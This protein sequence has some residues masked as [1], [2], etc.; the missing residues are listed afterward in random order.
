MRKFEYIPSKAL[1]EESHIFANQNAL[2][3]HSPVTQEIQPEPFCRPETQFPLDN[4]VV[5]RRVCACE[6]GI[7]F[8][9]ANFVIKVIDLSSIYWLDHGNRDNGSVENVRDLPASA[10]DYS[11]CCPQGCL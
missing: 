3:T 6:G 11:Q 10:Q 9:I 1:M 2:K 4:T 5:N 8:C 7:A